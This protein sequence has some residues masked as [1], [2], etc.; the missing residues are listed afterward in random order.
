MQPRLSPGYMLNDQLAAPII[1]ALKTLSEVGRPWP[2]YSTGNERPLPATFDELS[3]GLPE[4]GRGTDF[5][6][7]EVATFLIAGQIQ[8][9]KYLFAQLA[10]AFE[11]R[12]HHVGRRLAAVRQPGI[13]R[14]IV[15][16]LIDQEA[17]V[18]Q[19]S[20]VGWHGAV[21]HGKDRGSMHCPPMAL[22][23]ATAQRFQVRQSVYE[24][25]LNK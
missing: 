12:L 6:G 20:F 11:Y 17:H 13:V 18:A 7:I 10:A 5:A 16:H 8:G 4:S 25:P 24:C 21:F 3:V 9:C 1:S 23:A 2:P 22:S 14:R 15:E 19:G